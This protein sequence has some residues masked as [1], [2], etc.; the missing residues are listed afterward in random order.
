MCM[1]C[2]LTLAYT[3]S[4]LCIFVVKM[5]ETDGSIMIFWQALGESNEGG[6]SGSFFRIFLYVAIKNK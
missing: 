1:E 2:A 5:F 6:Q 4:N 3:N